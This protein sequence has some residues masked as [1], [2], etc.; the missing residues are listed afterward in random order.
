M[1]ENSEP[2]PIRVPGQGSETPVEDVLAERRYVELDGW[3]QSAETITMSAVPPVPAA[4][5]ADP[6]PA[7]PQRRL[8]VAHSEILPETPSSASPEDSDLSRT[9][10]A[11]PAR[12][13]VALLAGAGLAVIL[14][15]GGA[16]A[17]AGGTDK[18]PVTTTAA[19]A[20]GPVA[21]APEQHPVQNA[22]PVAI[23]TTEVSV[24]P[25]PS[26]S[27]SSS[28]SPSAT[29]LPLLTIGHGPRTVTPHPGGGRT[30]PGRTSTP[31]PELSAVYH[32]DD[33][34]FSGS[35]Q[36]VNSGDGAAQDWTVTLN[37]PGGETVS[38]SSGAV[39]VSQSGSSVT[40]RPSGGPVPPGGSVSFGFSLATAPS[41]APGGCA[42]NGAACS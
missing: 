41:S 1:R 39:S 3:S 31:E 9:A 26:P 2:L 8:V 37:V 20:T 24:S 34:Q 29:V 33:T 30:T 17:L 13:R 12:R 4:P 36:V 7:A 21:T 11:R 10:A 15:G 32:Y 38:V 6:Y 27:A 5:P 28:A 22:K 18:T 40:F 42:V 25:T 35:V 16:F 23:A 19:A 14:V